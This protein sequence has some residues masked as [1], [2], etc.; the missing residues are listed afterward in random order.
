MQRRGTP[1]EGFAQEV[2]RTHALVSQFLLQRL[3]E[4]GLTGLAPSHGDILSQLFCRGEVCMRELSE[5]IGRDPSTV[6][7]LTKKLVALGFVATRKSSEDRRQT[8]VFL[9]D[10]GR[11]LERDFEE[12]SAELR[13]MWGRGVAPDELACASRVLDVMRENLA[14]ALGRPG[15]DGLP[16]PA[17]APVPVPDDAGASARSGQP[18]CN[19]ARKDQL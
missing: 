19:S 7:A 4:R 6:T 9:T 10:R 18:A 16:R 11:G 1:A 2:S 14:S 13:S 5:A 12:I 8:T 3:A 15:A 17:R